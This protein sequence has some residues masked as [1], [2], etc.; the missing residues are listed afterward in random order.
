MYLRYN[1]VLHGITP[2]PSGKLNDAKRSYSTGQVLFLSILTNRNLN[3][4]LCLFLAYGQSIFINTA[5]SY[6]QDTKRL[7]Q[8]KDIIVHV[9]GVRTWD[10]VDILMKSSEYEVSFISPGKMNNYTEEMKQKGIHTFQCQPNDA[11]FDTLLHQLKPNLVIFDRFVT[12]EQFGWRVRNIAPHAALIIDSQDLHSLRH[13]RQDAIL[14][15]KTIEDI[16]STIPTVDSS[17]L[18]REVST[19]HRADHTLVV[20]SFEKHILTQHYGV[21]AEKI[22]LAPFYYPKVSVSNFP[23]WEERRNFTMI[24]NFRHD[25]NKDQF[26]VLNVHQ[27]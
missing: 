27:G 5:I 17:E 2:S 16:V 12:E 20:S 18:L 8:V 15:G 1:S 22:S 19:I 25:P 21:P 11:A 14:K 9:V 26:K 7:Q 4:R 3:V 10:L 13:A 23:S 6:S 24:G